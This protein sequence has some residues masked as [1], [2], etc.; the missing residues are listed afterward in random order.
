[1]LINRL[2][3]CALA[4]LALTGC[5]SGS[6]VMQKH[7]VDEARTASQD[8]PQPAASSLNMESGR[9]ASDL[10]WDALGS[11]EGDSSRAPQPTASDAAQQEPPKTGS[12]L[13]RKTLPAPAPQDAALATQPH[14]FPAPAANGQ[15][16][17]K[18]RSRSAPSLTESAAML[19]YQAAEMKSDKSAFGLW[20]KGV[21]HLFVMDCARLA[22]AN[23][24]AQSAVS[25]LGLPPDLQAELLGKDL[26]NPIF[27]PYATPSNL[28]DACI[29]L[30]RQGIKPECVADVMEVSGQGYS[31][32]FMHQGD[33][34]T[35][36]R[37][38]FRCSLGRGP[39]E[40]SGA[41]MMVTQ[42]YHLKE[43]EVQ[44]VKLEGV[45][46]R[47][48]LSNG[49]IGVYTSPDLEGDGLQQSGKL[50]IQTTLPVRDGLVVYEVI[51]RPR[52]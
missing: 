7:N 49:A 9:Y 37:V 5:A 24:D 3:T 27:I 15:H 34:L 51:S 4:A 25:A 12:H 2:L 36:D 45:T 10:K 43:S 41:P 33:Q 21:A 8:I 48:M 14:S 16:R 18:P 44:S 46:G 47:A 17:S 13:E 31:Q 30:A 22:T 40:G 32:L 28:G 1:M 38:H 29:K 6:A 52:R 11:D 23:P 35:I 26:S 19:A 20:S 50:I 42:P 39:K